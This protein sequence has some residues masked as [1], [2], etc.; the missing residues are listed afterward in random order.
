[1]LERTERKPQQKKI[2]VCQIHQQSESSSSV[3]EEEEVFVTECYIAEALSIILTVS[4]CSSV[5]I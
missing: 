2:N 4:H 5:F 3:K 1:M